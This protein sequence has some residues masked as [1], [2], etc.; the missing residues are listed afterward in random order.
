MQ[1]KKGEL[2]RFLGKKNGVAFWKRL[3]AYII[4]VFVINFIIVF[5]LL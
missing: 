3:L 2:D 1:L 4:D 5:K